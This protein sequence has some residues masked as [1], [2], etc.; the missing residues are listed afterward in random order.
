M[1]STWMGEG[2]HGSALVE[3][4]CYKPE[5]RGFDSRWCHWNIYGH[6]PSGC[7]MALGLTQSLTEMSNRNISYFLGGKGIRCILMCRLS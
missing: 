1:V 4:L 3:T 6:N 7:T 2:A 5:G